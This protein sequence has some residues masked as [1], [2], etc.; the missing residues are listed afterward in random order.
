[1]SIYIVNAITRT[2]TAQAS[3]PESAMDYVIRRHALIGYLAM[4][5]G[6]P[7]N[8]SECLWI[9]ERGGRKLRVGESLDKSR[10]TWKTPAGGYRRTTRGQSAFEV[11][12]VLPAV[13]FTA[14]TALAQR[15]PK[16]W[17]RSLAALV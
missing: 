3:S 8:N 9:M 15:Y 7:P 13:Q 10:G 11:V 1:M 2:V 16:V 4:R 14:R 6:F 12:C 5:K 17:R